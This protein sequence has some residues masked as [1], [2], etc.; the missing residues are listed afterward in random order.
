MGIKEDIALAAELERKKKE[1][2]HLVWVLTILILTTLVIIS[3]GM[4]RCGGYGARPTGSGDGGGETPTGSCTDGSKVGAT[5]RVLCEAPL[6]GEK[7]YVCKEDGKALELVLDCGNVKPPECTKVT[8]DEGL[9]PVIASK[10]ASCHSAFSEYQTA[11]VRIDEWVRRI[12]LSS[13]DPRRMPKIPLPEL[14]TDEKKVFSQWREDGLIKSNTECG[15]TTP[16]SATIQLNYIE[17]QILND[18]SKIEQDDRPFIRYLVSAHKLN[19]GQVMPVGKGAVDKALNSIVE[20][21]RDLLL[22]SFVDE[23][24]TIYRLDL[25]SFELNRTD[26][27]KI[28]AV[29]KINLESNT[30][31]GRTLKLLLATKKPWLHFD[32]FVDIINTPALYYDF[33]NVSRSQRELTQKLGVNYDDDLFR[34]DATLIGN[35]DSILTNQINRLISRHDSQDGY[36]W[37][38][39]DTGPSNGDPTKNL[40]AFPLL[41]E[42]GSARKFRFAAS[43]VIYSLPNGLQGYALFDNKGVRLNDADIN[44]VRD[45]ESMVS[46]APVIRNAISCHRCHASGINPARDE[47]R[48]HVIDHA[49]EFGVADTDRVKSLYKGQTSLNALFKI[50]N[51]RYAEALTK[52]GITPGVDPV[53]KARD[54]LLFNWT[55]VK[56]AA[57]L[58]LPV[59]ELRSCVNS[60]DEGRTEIGQILSGNTVT[61]DQI[62]QVL[63]VLKRDCRL[64]EERIN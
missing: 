16:P 60:S 59:V 52:L 27:L 21:D 25:R 22:T 9:K 46:P 5:K 6:T 56:L 40:F 29:D 15:S 32:N 12:S 7:V 28:E 24:K 53:N 34:L 14:S 44:V 36:F 13:Q 62:K 64:F 37:Q 51:K 4:T 49:D 57:F 10:C 54:E 50:D 61:F 45:V 1:G 23:K 33:L 19:E 8:F 58:F 38:T 42:T 41:P 43:E 11:V 20:K 47:I 3:L 18:L 55:D 39:Y 31:I 48:Q 35:N 17:T 26:W 30:D 63:P 2:W